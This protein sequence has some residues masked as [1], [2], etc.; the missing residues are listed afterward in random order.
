M[1]KKLITQ[2]FSAVFILLG[3]L[4]FV[5]NPIFGTFAV[6]TVHNIIHLAT[7]ILGFALLA[8]GEDGAETF[9]KIMTFVYGLVTILGFIMPVGMIEPTDKLLGLFT[10]NGADNYLHLVF[11]L[12]FAYLG[13]AGAPSRRTAAT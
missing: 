10:I 1:N 12:V 8:R 2:I 5:N 7:G 13:F 9:G 4:G 11:T 3:L 6:D